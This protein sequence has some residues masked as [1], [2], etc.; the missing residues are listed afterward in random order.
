MQHEKWS[1][2]KCDEKNYELGEIR[3][4]GSF[5]SR[6]INIQNKKYSAVSCEKC[7]YTEFYKSQSSSTMVN[8]FDFFTT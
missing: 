7:S 4:T 8:V 6:I 1:Y 5:W 3:V 2:P